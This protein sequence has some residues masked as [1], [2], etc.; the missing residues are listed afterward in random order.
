MDCVGCGGL[1]DPQ[2]TLKSKAC[3]LLCRRGCR[4]G[5]CPASVIPLVPLLLAAPWD[6]QG[7]GGI[8]REPSGPLGWRPGRT[9]P[10]CD[11]GRVAGLLSPVASSLAN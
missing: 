9:R 7:K 10:A 11:L 1:T 6:G 3:T 8:G 5:T 4:Q 2:E